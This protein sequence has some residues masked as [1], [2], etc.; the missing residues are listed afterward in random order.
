MA[1]FGCLFTRGQDSGILMIRE[2]AVVH[3][4]P[5]NRNGCLLICWLNGTAPMMLSALPPPS[6]S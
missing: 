1:T 6:R 2:A 4:S 5:F 3:A